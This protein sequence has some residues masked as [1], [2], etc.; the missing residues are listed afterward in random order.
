MR[1]GVIR[2]LK[3]ESRVLRE[4]KTW[5][6]DTERLYSRVDMVVLDVKSCILILEV[7]EYAHQSSNYTLACELARMSDV[8]A[9]LRICKHTQ[10]IYWLRYSPVGKYYVGGEERIWPRESREL[11]LKNHIFSMM[12][13]GFVP[14]GDEHIHYMFYSRVSEGGPPII[15]E[16]K[17][18]PETLKKIVSWAVHTN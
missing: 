1:E 7:D 10:P 6:T 5:E 11:A 12:E 3:E 18:Y 17:E 13:P 4:M 8:N 15:L 16:N 14:E 9:F 2:H